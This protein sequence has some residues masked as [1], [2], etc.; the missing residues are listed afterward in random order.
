[1]KI[2]QIQVRP[3][4]DTEGGGEKIFNHLK[5]LPSQC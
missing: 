3:E 4:S 5:N 1:M 2:L